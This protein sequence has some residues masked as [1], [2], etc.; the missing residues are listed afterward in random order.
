MLFKLSLAP[1]SHL[2]RDE[3]FHRYPGFRLVA[4]TTCSSAPPDV[5][6]RIECCSLCQTIVGCKSVNFRRTRSS[7]GKLSCVPMTSTLPLGVNQQLINDDDWEWI[8]MDE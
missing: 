2:D 1:R 4:A 3:L 8:Y 7:S 5:R 6:S